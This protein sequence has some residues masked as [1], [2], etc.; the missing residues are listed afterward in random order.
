MHVEINITRRTIL[1]AY[2]MAIRTGRLFR[3]HPDE[4]AILIISAKAINLVKSK[5]LKEILLKIFEKINP[6]LTLKMKALM[7]G[8]EIAKRRVEQALIIG[9]ERASSWLR[10]LNYILYL[11]LSYMSTPLIYR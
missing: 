11:G 7:I 6:K 3:L 9:Y 5:T 8:L 1:K 4:K 10:D 2:R